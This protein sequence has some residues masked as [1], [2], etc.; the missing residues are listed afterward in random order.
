MADQV[1]QEAVEQVRVQ[2]YLNH[3]LL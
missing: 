2:S 3:Q 1:G